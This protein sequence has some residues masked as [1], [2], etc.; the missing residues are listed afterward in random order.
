MHS[1]IRPFS[2]I[3]VR[4][5]SGLVKILE[6][7]PNTYVV[8]W[9]CVSV[10]G[11]NNAYE[12]DRSRLFGFKFSNM[13]DGN[14]YYKSN[15]TAYKYA[16]FNTDILGPSATISLTPRDGL[17]LITRMR[18]MGN[19]NN[20]GNSLFQ[21]LGNAN[22][23][24]YNLNVINRSLQSRMTAFAEGGVSYGRVLMKTDA[25]ELKVG[26]TGKYIF[27]LAYASVSS[28]QMN[29][30]IDPANNILNASADVTAQYSS[31]I[32]NLGGGNSF[33]SQLNHRAGKGL[34]LD[35]PEPARGRVLLV[36]LRPAIEMGPGRRRPRVLH[37]A[38]VSIRR[39]RSPHASRARWPRPATL[40][41][42]RSPRRPTCRRSA[43]ARTG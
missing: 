29:V 31:N 24:Y 26:V 6:V 18:V 17:G 12:M 15:N 39:L 40:S 16:Y 4:L 32:D 2:N 9:L 8:G 7:V 35:L 21:L 1:Y 13:S 19:V 20:L 43:W 3:A 5:S 37:A 34:G 42:P 10:L 36:G 28:G 14:G 22:P 33:A 38:T 25:S 11:G 23:D 41:S 30:D 27:G